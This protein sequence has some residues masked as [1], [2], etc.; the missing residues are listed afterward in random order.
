MMGPMLRCARELIDDLYR[1]GAL[2]PSEELVQEL[3]EYLD[4]AYS[5]WLADHDK[6]DRTLSPERG[7]YSGPAIW[8]SAISAVGYLVAARRHAHDAFGAA[9]TDRERAAAEE[10]LSHLESAIKLLK[11]LAHE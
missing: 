9:R 2:D 4:G 6:G 5:D 1:H 8:D 7:I 10:A 3:A 11:G